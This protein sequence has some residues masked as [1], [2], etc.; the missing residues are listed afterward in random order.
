MAEIFWKYFW[1]MFG[2]KQDDACISCEEDEF[3]SSPFMIKR[4]LDNT[5]SGKSLRT[6]IICT[7]ASLK[8]KKN[9]EIGPLML[10]F[11]KYVDV[12][13]ICQDWKHAHF[14]DNVLTAQTG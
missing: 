10:I 14:F 7:Y 9:R 5:Y 3:F 6:C 12:G 2:N 8:E 11:N 4:M 13:E 1:F